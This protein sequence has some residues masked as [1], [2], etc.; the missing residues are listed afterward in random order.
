MKKGTITLIIF[1]IIGLITG[2]IVGQLLAPVPALS[3]LTKSVPITWQ[4]KADLQVIKYDIDLMI[5]LNLC[6]ILGLVGG[7]FLYRKL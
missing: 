3:F 5:R 2:I 7:F 4:P 6:S 1:L